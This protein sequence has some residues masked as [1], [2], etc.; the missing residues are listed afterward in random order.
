MKTI[1]KVYGKKNCNNCKLLTKLLDE[2]EI[3]YIYVDNEKELMKIGSEHRIMS[4]PIIVETK[5]YKS[6]QEFMKEKFEH[7][8]Y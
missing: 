7:E 8:K 1:L 4:A 5:I 6:Y 3:D 2:K